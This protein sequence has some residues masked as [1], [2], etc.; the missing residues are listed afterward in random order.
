VASSSVVRRVVGE[1]FSK[2]FDPLANISS[3]VFCGVVSAEARG[4]SGQWFRIGK[5]RHPIVQVTD[6]SHEIEIWYFDGTAE[7]RYVAI[8]PDIIVRDRPDHAF[9]E[10]SSIHQAELEY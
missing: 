6:R 1:Q 7:K 8:E 9:I 10:G 5:Y 3:G 2:R 4:C